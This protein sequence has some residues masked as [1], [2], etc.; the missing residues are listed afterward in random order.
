MD[1]IKLKSQ[2]IS[3]KSTHTPQLEERIALN[4]ERKR[5]WKDPFSL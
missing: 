3:A 5:K 4:V 2:I 1:F